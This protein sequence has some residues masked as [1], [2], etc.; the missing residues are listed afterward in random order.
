MRA[1]A[2][3]LAQGVRRATTS[4]ERESRRH[5]EVLRA[6]DPGR[7]LARGWSLTRDASGTL[8]RSAAHLAPGDE[9]ST[10]FVDGV[11]VSTVTAGPEAVKDD[12]GVRDGVVVGDHAA[13]GPVASEPAE[14]G[15][16]AEVERN[17]AGARDARARTEVRT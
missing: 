16:V 13:R 17:V 3:G 11:V 14:T 8:V 9:I 6:Y 2:S 1:G 10:R 5:R 12:H 4:F 15:R 7:Q